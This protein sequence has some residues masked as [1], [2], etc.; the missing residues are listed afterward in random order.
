VERRSLKRCAI[1]LKP[2]ADVIRALTR[3]PERPERMLA[4]DA[5]TES[6]QALVHVFAL[7][8]ASPSQTGPS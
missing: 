1:D 3:D 4:D 2:S 7:S 6:L 8:L 5:P